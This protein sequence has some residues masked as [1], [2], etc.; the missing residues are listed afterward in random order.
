QPV[1]PLTL[2]PDLRRN[3]TM[4]RFSLALVL[5]AVPVLAAELN[6]VSLGDLPGTG[7]RWQVGEVTVRAPPEEVQRWFSD[8][9]GWAA[10]FPDD[11]WAVDLGPASDGTRVARFYSQALGRVL[12]VRLREQPGL[13]VYAGSGKGVTTQGKIFFE[14]AGPGK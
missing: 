1:D 8:P 4:R 9:S 14:A 11:K 5:Y 6:V 2:V 7:D 12:T 10:R 13:I 3:R